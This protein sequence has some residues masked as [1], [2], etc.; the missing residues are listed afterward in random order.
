MSRN[1]KSESP[2]NGPGNSLDNADEVN[3]GETVADAIEH[4]RFS[5]QHGSLFDLVVYSKFRSIS[6]ASRILVHV[7]LY[8]THPD[9]FAPEVFPRSCSP[10]AHPPICPG[11]LL[12]SAD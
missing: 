3:V 7:V 10:A 8:Q 5:W 2:K 4:G 11:R 6:R 9:G 12:L 1:N